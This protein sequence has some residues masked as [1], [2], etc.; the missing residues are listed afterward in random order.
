MEAEDLFRDTRVNTV[1]AWIITLFIGL[2]FV[3]STLNWDRLWM[4]FSGFLF[5]LILIPTFYYK[6]VYV[7]LPWELL[8]IASIPVIVRAFEVSILASQIATYVSF[9]AVALIIAVEL[10]IFTSLKFSH[11]FSI[12]FLV[13]STLAIGAVWSVI[14][15]YMDSLLGTSYLTTNEALMYEWFKIS[16]AGMFAGLLFDIYF[17][18]RDNILRRSL[19]RVVGI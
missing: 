2:V 10:H 14:R 18:R 15:F 9:A 8:F 16:V 19:K 5:T 12:G 7:T 11:G 3:E 1:L 6:D 17:R 4:V 13:V